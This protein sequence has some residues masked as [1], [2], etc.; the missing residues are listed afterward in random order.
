MNIDDFVK[1]NDKF[2]AADSWMGSLHRNHHCKTKNSWKKIGD[3]ARPKGSNDDD[4]KKITEQW[5]RE[6]EEERAILQSNEPSSQVKSK[7]TFFLP[8]NLSL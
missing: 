8:W 3:A 1:D 5:I 6:I 4:W 2:R 7:S